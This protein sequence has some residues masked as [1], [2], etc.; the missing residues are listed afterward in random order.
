MLRFPLL[1]LTSALVALPFMLSAQCT[2]HALITT[3]GNWAEEM[4]WE[5]QDDSGA[6]VASFQG[7]ANFTTVEQ[8]ICLDPGCFTLVMTDTWGD[9]WNGGE[10]LIVPENGEPITAVL[11]DGGGAQIAFGV[12]TEGC[13]TAIEQLV[14]S[15]SITP[16]IAS[17]PVHNRIN[18]GIQNRGH[19]NPSQEFSDE[20]EFLSMLEADL[21]QRFD[22]ESPLAK[23]PFAQYRNFFN[24]DAWW[25][26]DALHDGNGWNW[27]DFKQMRDIHYLPWQDDEHGWATLFSISKY[28]GG[29]G[30]G[31]QPDTRT[32]DGYM[33]GTGWET[34][35]HEFSHTMPQIP[36]E[37]TASGEWSGGNCWEGPNTTSFLHPD[38]VPW[39]LWIDEE[40]PQ[41]TP[42]MLDH[43]E[44]IGVF[45]GALTNYFGC[46]RPTARG[47]IM[48]AGG[49]EE[50]YGTGMC[51]PCTQRIISQLYRYVDVIENPLPASPL[52]EAGIG[53]ELVFSADVVHPVPNTQHY[54]WLVNGAEVATGTT[55]LVW[56]AGSCTQYE[57]VLEVRDT[58]A[59]HRFDPGF[60]DIYRKPEERHAWTVVVPGSGGLP[61][62]LS[63]APV[64]C[65]GAATGSI[66][67]DPP[68]T[69]LWWEGND[70]GETMGGLTAGNYVVWALDGGGCGTSHVVEVPDAEQAEVRICVTAA[71]AEVWELSAALFL[72]GDPVD[73]IAWNWSGVA[74]SEG[75]TAEVEV[76]NDVILEVG[77][78]A[79]L[80]V[81][82]TVDASLV[83]DGGDEAAANGAVVPTIGVVPSNGADGIITVDALE[84][85][86][87]TWSDGA[88]PNWTRTGL[89]PGD[90][91]WFI[92][93]ALTC[94]S[95]STT[96]PPVSGTPE[97]RP[98]VLASP[99]GCGVTA[100]HPS[101]SDGT[102]IQW[103]AGADGPILGTDT[104]LGG[105]SFIPPADGSYW[106]DAGQGER[107]G[108][109]F[110][111]PEAP[112]VEE[113]G[114]GILAVT[115]PQPGM[116][117][118]WWSQGCPGGNLLAEGPT[119]APDGPG[120]FFVDAIP[121]GTQAAL[122]PA[123][124]G[125]LVW[126]M[127]AADLDGDGA[128]DDPAP[129]TSSLLDWDFNPG[130]AWQDWFAYRAHHQNDL[131]V[132]DFATIWLQS[133]TEGLPGYRSLALAYRENALTF[134]NR[135]PMEVL[136]ATMPFDSAGGMILTDAHAAGLWYLDGA[137]VEP[138]ATEQD[139]AFHIF[140][141]VLEQPA[142]G[143]SPYTEMRWE[144]EL[145]ELLLFN[146]ALTP[147][148]MEGV[149]EFLRRKWRAPWGEDLMAASP[150]VASLRTGVVWDGTTIGLDE[151]SER[152]LEVRPN[153]AFDAPMVQWPEGEGQWRLYDGLGTLLD[154]GQVFGEAPRSARLASWSHL[155][156]GPLLLVWRPDGGSAESAQVQRLVKL[157]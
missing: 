95:G 147:D 114:D 76:P 73:A 115:N 48:G 28:G 105:G 104:W 51:S 84:G 11:E 22:P 29:G 26:E 19:Q 18:W 110:H 99:D 13:L 8:S 127:D 25:W 113:I 15:M 53:E 93:T 17:G 32:G 128:I 47:C 45:E 50:G 9:G 6:V 41:P 63:A 118:R 72:G 103:M 62:T 150:E 94:L 119:H 12:D 58:T 156:A 135:A 4:D 145:G 3:T 24:L 56:T 39:R 139:F 126:R 57:V 7:A 117:Y 98:V 65:N 61:V 85:S 107:Y 60:A 52:V 133:M 136:N 71:N 23:V 44:D 152:R 144:G 140:G 86:T 5:I 69:Q 154:A 83:L 20:A 129:A 78:T 46:F 40:T 70:Q 97:P 137:V 134:P 109:A 16:L 75:G 153:P 55:T 149:Q 64:S 21:L 79:V 88:A 111:R 36:D 121:D 92:E 87:L 148:Q 125:S 38:S 132:A 49:F 143:G 30:A 116:T 43:L 102:S 131:G 34:L 155:P 120:T 151:A 130:G 124:L 89:P 96:V 142:G 112:I 141:A 67:A 138:A 42:Y 80:D 157:R 54:R 122:D 10:L 91:G 68:G 33:Y 81:T 37:Y 35:L 90:Y 59:M 14:A 77:V 108:F 31:V 74:G 82:C 66:T 2:E 1:P 100:T 27:P 106:L 101:W 123:G 146:A